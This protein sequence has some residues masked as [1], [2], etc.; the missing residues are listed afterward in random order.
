M[1]VFLAKM[2]IV[3]CKSMMANFVVFCIKMQS[4]CAN[5]Y[6]KREWVG[7]TIFGA[8]WIEEHLIKRFSIHKIIVSYFGELTLMN[9]LWMGKREK[10]KIGF[11][12]KMSQHLS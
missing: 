1:N 11:V 9:S 10:N 3:W 4:W 12:Q 6:G 7:V 8:K 2:V 5:F